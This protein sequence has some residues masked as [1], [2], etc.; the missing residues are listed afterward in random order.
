[1]SRLN[2]S[3]TA[4]ELEKLKADMDRADSNVKYFEAQVREA[5]GY[6]AAYPDDYGI[7]V[8]LSE[9]TYQLEDAKV[10]YSAAEA[11]YHKALVD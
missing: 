11:A 10:A 6:S 5:D 8:W 4:A 9:S 1:M 3:R 2:N 7:E